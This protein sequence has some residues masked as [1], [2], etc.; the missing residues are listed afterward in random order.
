M[1]TLDLR[2]WTKVATRGS[3][4]LGMRTSVAVTITRICSSLITTAR[5]RPSI[6]EGYDSIVS[7]ARRSREGRPVR[8]MIECFPT[9][10]WYDNPD[11]GTINHSLK[12]PAFLRPVVEAGGV[13]GASS[14]AATRV[15]RGPFVSERRVSMR[16]RTEGSHLL[17][18]QYDDDAGRLAG[19]RAARARLGKGYAG[20]RHRC[21]LVAVDNLQSTGGK[22][23]RASQPA[24]PLRHVP[25]LHGGGHCKAQ[26]HCPFGPSRAQPELSHRSG[27]AIPFRSRATPQ[28]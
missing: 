5:S 23:A 27:W 13:S 28:C 18:V 24:R 1:E 3:L 11:T 16:S 8:R 9:S 7:R 2:S 22:R 14:T 19:G 6:V 17:V 12:G 4:K 21:L 10:S 15:E 20:K 26:M 25:A